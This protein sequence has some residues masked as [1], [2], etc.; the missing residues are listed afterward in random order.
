MCY[1][2][3]LILKLDNL[4]DEV[5]ISPDIGYDEDENGELTNTEDL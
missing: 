2:K 3:L 5:S 4:D 1:L